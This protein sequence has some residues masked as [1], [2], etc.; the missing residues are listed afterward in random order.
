MDHICS[1]G[2]IDTIGHLPSRTC[3]HRDTRRI[4]DDTFSN[5]RRMWNLWW[6]NIRMM[7]QHILS[8]YLK[9]IMWAEK[10]TTLVSVLH[11]LL[12]VHQHNLDASKGK[13][14]KSSQNNFCFSIQHV[15]RTS[16]INQRLQRWEQYF[17]EKIVDW[18]LVMAPHGNWL[19]G[20]LLYMAGPS[21]TYQ[22]NHTK[23]RKSTIT[24]LLLLLVYHPWV[25]IHPH[26]NSLPLSLSLSLVIALTQTRY[27]FSKSRHL[28][29]SYSKQAQSWS[30]LLQEACQGCIR[31][32]WTT[33]L[34]CI[35]CCLPQTTPTPNMA[36][37]GSNQDCLLAVIHIND[38]SC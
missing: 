34:A 1:C 4:Q 21:S 33:L 16:S 14:Q 6:C 26:T 29:P 5:T 28:Q 9:P 37:L 13:I 15:L 8:P 30:H 22:A 32:V 35:L 27:V 7:P 31:C 24:S 11:H 36:E 17:S 23:R 18:G 12:R 25:Q 10:W 3:H 38:G 19:G 2:N 20:L